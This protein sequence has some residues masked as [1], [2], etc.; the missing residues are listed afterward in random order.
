MKLLPLLLT[1]IICRSQKSLL[2]VLNIKKKILKDIVCS[3]AERSLPDDERK[4]RSR[5]TLELSGR[6][7]FAGESSHLCTT[8]Y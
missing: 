1:F 2:N 4:V 6:R 3:L 5:D 8:K 7:L